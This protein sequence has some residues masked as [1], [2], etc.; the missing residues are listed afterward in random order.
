MFIFAI[1]SYGA[2]NRASC[3]LCNNAFNPHNNSAEAVGI[4][5]LY[6]TGE[7]TEAWR[8]SVNFPRSQGWQHD[9]RI[10]FW[11]A[12]LQSLCSLPLPPFHDVSLL[13]ATGQ[14]WPQRK[15]APEGQCHLIVF[16]EM[17]APAL[18][19]GGILQWW[20]Q[21]RLALLQRQ[22]DSLRFP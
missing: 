15:G 7:K 22:R 1:V 18:W 11:A 2:R 13:R 4:I 10:R 20:Q 12:W 6:L 5:S 14:P 8:G 9:T 21:L 3:F 17:W 19:D 16:R